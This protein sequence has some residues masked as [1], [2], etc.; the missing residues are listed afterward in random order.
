MYYAVGLTDVAVNG[1][2]C[3][4]SIT[5]PKYVIL[6]TGTSGILTGIDE[7]GTGFQ[8]FYRCINQDS[9]V[10]F[11]L[12]KG[13]KLSFK[14][15]K[16]SNIIQKSPDFSP[17]GLLNTALLG[18]PTLIGTVISYDIKNKRLIFN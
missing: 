11:T 8:D 15:S 3:G 17:A 14:Y 18:L 1:V 4:D 10:T 7:F 12:N 13:V 16:A 6:D 5:K 9:T 2:S